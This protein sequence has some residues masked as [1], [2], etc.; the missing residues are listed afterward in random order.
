MIVG[1]MVKKEKVATVTV[2]FNRKNLLVNNIESII[3][4]DYKV[5][6]II[7]VDNHSTDGTK[8]EITKKFLKNKNIK[9]VYLDENTGGAG[10][11]YYGCKIAYESGYDWVILMDDDGKFEN[12]EGI[13]NLFKIIKQKKLSSNEKVM[14]NSIVLCEKNKMPFGLFSINDKFEDIVDKADNGVILN[15]INPFNGTLIS[16]KL[17]E[18]IGFPNK[19]LF[20]TSD[21]VEYSFRAD[22][23]NAY[24]ATV[25]NSLYFHPGKK[26]NKIQVLGKTLTLFTAVSPVMQYYRVRNNIYV[27]SIHPKYKKRFENVKFISKSLLTIFV[28]K[29]EIFLNLKMLI[30]GYIDGKLKRIGKTIIPK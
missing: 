10:G 28:N 11:F 26:R 13:T 19:D 17:I 9:Y 1:D 21:E 27:K 3:K 4:Q 7:I 25:V 5:D 2:T 23:S 15:R 16:K 22:E 6:C 8:E 14:L 18:E 20:L 12:S 24:I 30:K 29:E